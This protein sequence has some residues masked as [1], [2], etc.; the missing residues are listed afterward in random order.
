MTIRGITRSMKTR[1]LFCVISVSALCGAQAQTNDTSATA[2][3][4]DSF[5][6]TGAVL[7]APTGMNILIG[8]HFNPFACRLSGG[9]WRKNW[10]GAQADL[11]CD[12]IHQSSL[13]VGVSL[14]A[15]VTAADPILPND[16]QESVVQVEK[17]RY[18]GLAL[19]FFY[20]GFFLQTGMAAGAGDYPNPFFTF[21]CGYLFVF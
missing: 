3:K 18:L 6:V 4:E 10:Y 17:Q 8:H 14:V 11:S 1:L 19:D 20:G 21:Q 13:A 16:K 9:Y 2:F 5:T 15:G 7:G 12:F